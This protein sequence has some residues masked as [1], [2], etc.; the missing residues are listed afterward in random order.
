MHKQLIF[1]R[2]V[3]YHQAVLYTACMTETT[4]SLPSTPR[5]G[6]NWNYLTQ[7]VNVLEPLP[8]Q[9]RRTFN[10]IAVTDLQTVHTLLK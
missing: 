7:Q 8:K 5:R 9:L 10:I 6:H 4:V 3:T 1:Y 2:E